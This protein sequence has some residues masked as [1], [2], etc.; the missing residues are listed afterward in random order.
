MS[1]QF[2]QIAH[3]F[4]VIMLAG[5]TFAALAVASARPET[6]RPALIGSGVAAMVALV[7]GFGL[8]GLGRFGLPGWVV[9]KLAAWVALA[10]LTG[11]AYRRPAQRRPLAAVAV[12][13]VLLSVVMV[14]SKP[15]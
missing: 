12:L 13:A 8:L 7:S 2:Y 15:F 1:Y 6:R 5:S 3:L 11:L 10:A 4:S 14:V 9:V